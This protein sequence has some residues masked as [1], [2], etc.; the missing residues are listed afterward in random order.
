[1]PAR[2]RA[3][4]GAALSGVGGAR[5]HLPGA[6]GERAHAGLAAEEGADHVGLGA[7]VEGGLEG[8]EGAAGGQGE[9]EEELIGQ[10]AADG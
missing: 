7:R 10:V 1:M 4:H 3:A 2:C 9:G 8:A 6:V 5:G